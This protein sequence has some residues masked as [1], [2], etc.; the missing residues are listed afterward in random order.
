[1]RKSEERKCSSWLYALG[2]VVSSFALMV[3]VLNVNSACMFIAHQAEL[4]NSAKNLRKF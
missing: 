3:T 1:M 2:S 4:P